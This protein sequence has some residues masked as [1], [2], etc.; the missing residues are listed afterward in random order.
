MQLDYC[1]LLANNDWIHWGDLDAHHENVHNGQF[2]DDVPIACSRLDLEAVPD[3]YPLIS[4]S[5][6]LADVHEDAGL[7]LTGPASGRELG[8]DSGDGMSGSY[9]FQYCALSTCSGCRL[10]ERRSVC[11]E[12]VRILM[13]L[14]D[15]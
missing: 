5:T 2:F 10:Q 4:V 11:Q 9:L 12:V 3:D 14:C 1:Q 8:I 13:S 7:L 15:L 6:T